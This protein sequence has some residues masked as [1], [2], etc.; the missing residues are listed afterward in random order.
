MDFQFLGGATEVGRLAMLYRDGGPT[1]LFDYGMLPQDPPVYPLPAP[2]V[3]ALFVTHSH[4]DHVGMVPWVCSREEVDVF[5]TPPTL[6]VADLLLTDSIKVAKLE[7]YPSP[8]STNEL[9]RAHRYFRAADHGESIEVRGTEVTFHRA[10][11]IPGA[12]MYEVNGPKT[13]LFTGDLH[14]LSTDLVQGAAPVKCDVLVLES[15][16]AGRQHKD[17]EKT[18]YRFLGKIREVNE[19]G[20]LAVV[21]SFAVGRTQDILLTLLRE[22]FEVHVDGMG[23]TVNR[24]YSNHPQYLTS[25][26]KLRKAIHR[27]QE[28]R[29]YRMR[30]EALRGEVI[31][32]TSGMLDGGPI[33]RYLESIREDTRSALLLTGYQVEG[34][35]G[36]RLVEGGVMA[37][38][39]VDLRPKF[40]VDK[41]D[42]SAHAG[43]DDLVRFVEGCD[44][45]TVV[46]MH[47]DNREALAEAL[48]GR[49]VLLPREG[50]WFSVS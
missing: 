6:D 5:A 23:R 37:L 32:T 20:G 4:L 24:I 16:Y 47:G 27:A 41:F 8:Y 50:E 2:D 3:D 21:A 15:T 9:R 35:Q 22:R 39:G 13:T 38:N 25:A 31:V 12:T 48:D 19:R 36:R 17:R 45:E 26:K 43:H 42:F 29:N 11:H 10:G 18:I 46:L 44:P 40:E 49:E 30:E 7:G 28:V 1:L 14:T 34:T 33:V